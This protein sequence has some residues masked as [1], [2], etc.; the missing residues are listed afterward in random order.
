[1][2]KIYIFC[3]IILYLTIRI[4]CEEPKFDNS[5]LETNSTKNYKFKKDSYQHATEINRNYKNEKKTLLVIELFRNGA[6]GPINKPFGNEA[7]IDQAGYGKLTG[8]GEKQQYLLGRLVSRLYPE[9]FKKRSTGKSQSKLHE[10][11]S[12]SYSKNIQSAQAHLLGIFDFYN[13]SKISKQFSE[14]FPQYSEEE[15]FQLFSKEKVEMNK[16]YSLIEGVSNVPVQILDEEI[17][18]IAMSNFDKMCPR[19]QM[20]ISDHHKHRIEKHLGYE[21][22]NPLIKKISEYLDQHNFDAKRMFNHDSWDIHSISEFYDYLK[23]YQYYHGQIYKNI[24]TEI[25]DDMKIIANLNIISKKWPRKNLVKLWTTKFILLQQQLMDLIIEANKNKS[26]SS[27]NNLK[28]IGYSVDDFLTPFQMQL[29]RTTWKCF[30][31]KIMH[32]NPHNPSTSENITEMINKGQPSDN[33]FDDKVDCYDILEYSSNVIFEIARDHITGL[34]S[35]RVL[36]DGK[37]VDEIGGIK[38]CTRPEEGGYCSYKSFK[39]KM[40]DIFI[41]SQKNWD[42]ECMGVKIT[43]VSNIFLKWLSFKLFYLLILFQQI[44]LFLK[45]RIKCV[46]KQIFGEKTNKARFHIKL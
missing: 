25:M 39:E 15:V 41:L 43:N 38:I 32:D 30:E 14:K 17:I 44:W 8:T 45:I 11:Y 29:T 37:H 35:A 5:H 1:M 10:M 9:V 28:Y 19:A 27:D 6:R 24:E 4:H 21:T 34:I 16:S 12:I 31:R 40:N 20:E 2:K 46:E 33:E 23:S 26:M 18:N 36:I 13:G 3:V 7:W 22:N 42:Y